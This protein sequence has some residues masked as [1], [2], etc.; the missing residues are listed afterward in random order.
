MAEPLNLADCTDLGALDEAIMHARFS[1]L[2]AREHGASEALC[3]V[4]E[5]WQDRL[6][7][8]RFEVGR[9]SA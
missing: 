6:L 7:E 5:A 2:D 4:R 1:V 8:R 9:A 3:R